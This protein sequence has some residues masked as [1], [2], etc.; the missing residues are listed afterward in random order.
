[1]DEVMRETLILAFE[2]SICS[3][4]AK[5]YETGMKQARKLIE[6]IAGIIGIA[7]RIVPSI[8]TKEGLRRL[9]DSEMQWSKSEE[10]LFLQLLNQLPQ[11]LRYGLT[12]TGKKAAE[13]L[14]PPSTGRKPTLTARQSQEALDYIS[15]LNRK[16]APMSAAKG[17]AAQKFGCSRRTI[18][19]LWSSRKSIP[20]DKPSIEN[21]VSLIFT[22]FKDVDFSSGL[23]VKNPLIGQG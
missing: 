20:E 5:D 12:M 4:G 15:L 10:V 18:A 14:P 3:V 21:L 23:S 17:R 8:E 7:N 1:M 11:L 16:G 9:L 13:T 22:K 19:R 6:L 2:E